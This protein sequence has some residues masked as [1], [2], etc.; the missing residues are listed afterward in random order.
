MR[1]PI[2]YALTYPERLDGQLPPLPLSRMASLN[3]EAPDRER[4]PSL[5]YAYSAGERGGTAPAVL[6]AANEEAVALFLEGKITFC[7]IFDKVSEALAAH[8][9]RPVDRL[10]TVLEAD[11]WARR[12]V[13][14]HGA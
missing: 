8:T 5:D 10:E 9:V 13:K 2:Q 7:G 1:L 11:R 6:N 3:F 12:Y 4:F 14:E